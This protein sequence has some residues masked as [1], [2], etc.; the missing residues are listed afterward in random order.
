MIAIIKTISIMD[1]NINIM[2][3]INLT[4]EDSNLSCHF[5]YEYFIAIKLIKLKIS[6]ITK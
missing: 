2:R 6:Q 1:N 3:D 5:L 4:S